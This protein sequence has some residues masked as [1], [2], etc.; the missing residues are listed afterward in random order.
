M[1][2]SDQR[3]NEMRR[4][5]TPPTYPHNGC[6]KSIE[7]YQLKAATLA[8]EGQQVFTCALQGMAAIFAFHVDKTFVQVAAIKITVNDLAKIRSE[9]SVGPLKPFLVD[10]DEGFPDD[11]RHSKNN[12]LPVVCGAYTRRP[13][14]S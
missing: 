12:R 2:K 3:K 9:E 13:G 4:L 14:R 1:R 7:Y 8:R 11:P 5:L 10:L 6:E